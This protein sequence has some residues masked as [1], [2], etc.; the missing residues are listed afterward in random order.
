MRQSATFKEFFGV[1]DCV[2][3]GFGKFINIDFKAAAGSM[4]CCMPETALEG[5][6][7]NP[8]PMLQQVTAPAFG[9]LTKDQA[10]EIAL[11]HAG[12]A[13]ANTSYVFVKPDYDDGRATY[14]VEFHVGSKKYNYDI[15]ANSGQII[16][17]DI[18]MNDFYDS[19]DFYDYD[20]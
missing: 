13:K 4:R 5:A 11:K 20:D 17:F 6:V 7:V 8:K 15:D 12:V 16:E 18:D 1:A 10:L 3:Y 2:F 14:D 19:D 9:T